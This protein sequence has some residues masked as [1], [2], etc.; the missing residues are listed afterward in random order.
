MPRTIFLLLL[1][2]F[3]LTVPARAQGPAR[4]DDALAAL[5]VRS[6]NAFA[7][8]L[9]A[10]L[11]AEVPA[12]GNVFCSPHSVAAC[13]GLAYAGARGPTAEQMSK[14]LQLNLSPAQL[15]KGYRALRA[16][17]SRRAAEKEGYQL[18]IASALW[19][20]K[21]LGLRPEFVQQ[22]QA[23]FGAAVQ[24]VDFAASPEKAR[25][26]INTWG[27]EQTKGKF[28]EIMPPGT[29]N[30]G[31]EVVLASAIY[32]KA[33]W[34]APFN[35]KGTET[36]PF[37]V[38]PNR[39]VRVPLMRQTGTFAYL[40][41]KDF[42]VIELP[43]AGGALSMVALL[44]DRALAL[45]EF[46]KRLT[47]ANLADWLGR[48]KQQELQ[49]FLPR[50]QVNYQ[51]ELR[52]TLVDLGMP[53]AF[54]RD[55]DFSGM[56]GRRNFH[57]SAVMHRAFVRVDEDGTEAAAA[58]TAYVERGLTDPIV[59]RADHPFIYLLRDPRSGLIL[60]AGRLGDPSPSN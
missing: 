60:F 31:T 7:L 39:E 48:L 18:Q 59:F 9:Y 2:P 43:Y 28:P 46:E 17:L 51:R 12:D 35:K 23:G 44:P 58:T 33:A 36:A 47:G 11:A 50:F 55:A 34:A 27:K 8:E 3:S 6:S 22:A 57:L 54:G 4:P 30:A 10:R 20:Q 15:P 29:V 56:T 13:L 38:T 19:G 52:E 49:L 25:L 32:C 14:A 37:F 21:G 41:G 53:L 45:P 24:E 40:R 5:V 26:A 42:R 16:A 1:L